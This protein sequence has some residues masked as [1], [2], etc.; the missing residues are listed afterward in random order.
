MHLKW[1]TIHML[2]FTFMMATYIILLTCQL[3]IPNGT[4]SFCYILDI[5]GDVFE[6]FA[7]SNNFQIAIEMSVF[8][9]FLILKC[10]FDYQLVLTITL[11]CKSHLYHM[12]VC[13]KE[14]LEFILTTLYLNYSSYVVDYCIETIQIVAALI[15]SNAGCTA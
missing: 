9:F 11:G 13:G 7:H 2:N 14:F 5:N 12:C 3:C 4:P 10:T 1:F 8:F 15:G 6:L